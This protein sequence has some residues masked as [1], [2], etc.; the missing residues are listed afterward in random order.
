[1][2]QIFLPTSVE[3]LGTGNPNVGKVVITPCH[4]GYG[5]TLGNALRR[6]LLSSLPGAAVES[7]KITGAS[8]EFSALTGVLED[9]VEIILNLKQMAVKS[10]SEQPVTLTLS[11]KG[12]GEVLAGDFSKNSDI[13]IANPE[14]KIA[15]ITDKNFTLEMDIT[16]GHGRGYVPVSEKETTQLSLGTIAIDSLYTP[17]R[18]V[19]YQVEMT[20]VGDV[21]DYEKLTLTIET[22]GTVAPKDALSQATKILM[23]HFSLVLNSVGEE[24]VSDSEIV[25]NNVEISEAGEAQKDESDADEKSKAKKPRKKSKK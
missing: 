6:V 14:L 25:D 3:F 13:E 22:N 23:D 16:I 5:T 19:G 15:T 7:V 12:V 2:E 4:Q 17:I 10:H 21:T 9:V 18:D 11:K 20:R 24:T 1:M 8:H